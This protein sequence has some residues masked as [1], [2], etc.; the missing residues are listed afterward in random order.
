MTDARV[1]PVSVEAHR[2]YTEKVAQAA[3]Q[4]LV[5]TQIIEGNTIKVNLSTKF[6]LKRVVS[7]GVAK[8]HPDDTFNANVGSCIAIYRAMGQEVPTCLYQAT[9]RQEGRTPVASAP[10]PA[11]ITINQA[12]TDDDIDALYGEFD[13]D[14]D[15]IA[16]AFIVLRR[17]VAANMAIRR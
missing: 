6:G 5:A 13:D 8:C 12:V 14:P 15:K 17:Y 4:N 10:N 9:T 1:N 7:T 11:P 3:Q 2:L 16:E